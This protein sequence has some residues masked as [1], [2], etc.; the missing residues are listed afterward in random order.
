MAESKTT[1]G[2][3]QATADAPHDSR[4]Y[5]EYL[6]TQDPLKHLRAEFLIPSK[7]DLARETLPEQ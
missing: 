6:T 7:A 1:I 3:G 5:A 4:E 2:G